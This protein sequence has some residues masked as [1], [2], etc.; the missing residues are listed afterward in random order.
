MIGPGR[1]QATVLVLVV[2]LLLVTAGLGIQAWNVHIGLLVT[3][4]G[5]IGLPTVLA[6]RLGGYRLVPTLGLRRP[7]RDRLGVSLRFAVALGPLASLTALGLTV[8]LVLVLVLLGGRYPG[9]SLP[10]A[11]P[12]DLAW[13]LLTATVLAPVCEELLFRGFLLR[14]FRSSGLHAAVWLSAVCFGLFHM[15]PVRFVPTAAL[16]VVFGYLAVWGGSVFPAMVAHTANNGLVLLVAFFLGGD[17]NRAPVAASYEAMRDDILRHLEGSTV[18]LGGADPDTVAR[19]VLVSLA[20]GFLAAG[21]LLAGA[22]ALALRWFARRMA[23]PEGVVL[24]AAGGIPGLSPGTGGNAEGDAGAAPVPGST[25][26]DLLRG[27][28]RDPAAW[29]F[30]VA[31]AAVW[32]RL[33]GV[34]FAG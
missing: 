4:V 33:L 34:Y 31:A 11:G 17:G 6:C 8:P 28:A 16:G 7:S 15:D 13:A 32:A 27:L 14:A 24:P 25:G 22:L 10:L 30:L 26:A 5:L 12:G 20:A 2:F 18:P 19:L 1:R 3:E 21:I 23:P 29:G 9:V